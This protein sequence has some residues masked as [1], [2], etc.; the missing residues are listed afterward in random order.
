LLLQK[1][2]HFN[3]CATLFYV[4]VGA[5]AA[6]CRKKNLAGLTLVE[7]LNAPGQGP[8]RLGIA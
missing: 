1:P 8:L 6:T 2:F 4:G 5:R 3:A 7:D